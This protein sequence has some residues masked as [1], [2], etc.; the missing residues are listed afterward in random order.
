V[1]L[2]ILV[3]LRLL[4]YRYHLHHL[5]ILVHQYFLVVL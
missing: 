4:Y 2:G 3:L 1:L 5:G